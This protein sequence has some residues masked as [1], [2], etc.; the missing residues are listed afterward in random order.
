MKVKKQH[1]QDGFVHD[2]VCRYVVD[3]EV[4]LKYLIVLN[5]IWNFYSRLLHSNVKVK[6]TKSYRNRFSTE[7]I[8]N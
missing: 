2:A 6:E 5:V 1:S 4:V 3:P 7:F 8:L